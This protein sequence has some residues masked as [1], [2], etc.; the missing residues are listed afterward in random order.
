MVLSRYGAPTYD[1]FGATQIRSLAGFVGF[2]L[3]FAVT[4]RWKSVVVAL[5]DRRAQVHIARGAF[6]G[7]FLGVSLGLFAAQRAGT[8]IASTIIATVPVL[9]IP[10]SVVLFHERV[11]LREVIGAAMAV[12]GVAILFLA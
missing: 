5:R 8:G 4:G 10:V 6:F 2:A 11:R 12:S 3:V 1:P 9:L 7:P